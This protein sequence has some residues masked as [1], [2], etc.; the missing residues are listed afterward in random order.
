MAERIRQTDR[1]PV[2]ALGE[3]ALLTEVLAKPRAVGV[4]VLTIGVDGERVVDPIR[5]VLVANVR[6]GE[7]EAREGA[8][9]D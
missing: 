7:L 4:V 5:E 8:S 6:I 2:V 9:A 3:I 1:D